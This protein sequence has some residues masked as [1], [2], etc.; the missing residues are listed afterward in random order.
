MTIDIEE[1]W[2]EYAISVIQDTI[3]QDENLVSGC[4]VEFFESCPEMMSKNPQELDDDPVFLQSCSKTLYNFVVHNIN[5]KDTYKLLKM[6]VNIDDEFEGELEDTIHDVWGTLEINE[7]PF[8]VKCFEK[9]HPALAKLHKFTKVLFEREKIVLLNWTG[10]T[11]K[12]TWSMLHS[13]YDKYIPE[14]NYILS[15][16]GWPSYP[17]ADGWKPIIVGLSPENIGLDDF[18]N[19]RVTLGHMCLRVI[20]IMEEYDIKYKFTQWCD[21]VY[22]SLHLDQL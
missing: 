8:L 5:Y 14:A 15:W 13:V 9:K 3:F 17:E 10:Q 4:I 1:I 19:K 2:N 22:V 16:W 11:G 6:K 21:L 7:V 20:P 18:S 12:D